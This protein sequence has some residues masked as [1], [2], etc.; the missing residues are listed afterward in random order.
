[1]AQVISL[2]FSLNV[3]NTGVSRQATAVAGLGTGFL[4][5]AVG[6]AGS[7]YDGPGG[8]WAKWSTGLGAASLALGAWRRVTLAESEALSRVSIGPWFGARRTSG[9]A[10]R[11]TF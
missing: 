7:H 5:L 1:V 11:V 3:L 4:G 10:A 2:T 8:T 6:L 9:L